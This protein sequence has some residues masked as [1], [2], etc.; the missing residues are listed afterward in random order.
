M[1]AAGRKRTPIDETYEDR[2][3]VKGLYSREYSS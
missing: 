3:S 2:E 1:S